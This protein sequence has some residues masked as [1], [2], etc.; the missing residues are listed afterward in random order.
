MTVVEPI[1]VSLQHADRFYINGD[2]VQPSSTDMFDVIEPST[3][4]VFLR[5]AA[6]KAE[7]VSNAVAA[8]R[9]AFDKGPWPR[10]SHVERGVYLHAI[11][12]QCDSRLDVLS[13]IHTS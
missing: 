10:M 1:A 7:D 12:E 8:A 2:W 11:A 3:E 4:N 13:R 6:A 5:V 9:Q